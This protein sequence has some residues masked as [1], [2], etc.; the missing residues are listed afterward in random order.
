[1]VIDRKI[2][3]GVVAGYMAFF[4]AIMPT[5]YREERKRWAKH[6]QDIIHQNEFEIIDPGLIVSREDGI[7]AGRIFKQEN[8]DV[9]LVIPTMAAPPGY[10]WEAVKEFKD[11]PLIVWDVHEMKKIPD[12]YT[13][14]D[15][16]RHSSNVGTI[17][18]TNVALRYGRNPHIL[19][20]TYDD[21]KV[22]QRISQL[23]RIG[24]LASKLR[25]GNIG[26]IGEPIDGYINVLAEEQDVKEK[27]GLSM[28]RITKEEFLDVF[29]SITEKQL[30]K[31]REW[32][33]QNSVIEEMADDELNKSIQLAL[34]L[35]SITERYDLLGGAYN[36]RADYGVKN[37]DIG[38]IGC[39]GISYMA[40][41]GKPYTCTGDIITS[42]AMIVSKNLGSNVLYCECDQIDY[43]EDYMLMANTG[44]S[45]F[46][47]SCEKPCIISTGGHS[48][49]PVKGASLFVQAKKGPGTLI[50]LSPKQNA[51][52]GWSLIIAPGE[53]L[54]TDHQQLRV[55]NAMFR[56]KNGPTPEAF[57][58]WCL[59]GATHH[60]ALSTG[61]LVEDL[62]LLGDFLGIET[63]II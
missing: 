18:F 41:V 27:I 39:L 55:G 40:T 36:C 28:K 26:I 3:V 57:Q 24:G 8:I 53:I 59:A 58:R 25:K 51:K 44:E 54:G 62:L 34:T 35:E 20:G 47:F 30:A 63:V 9:I 60:G 49:Q 22:H 61:D 21:P 46:C 15:L 32:L 33:S 52:G 29:Q 16:V 4:D 5:G 37:P 17:M 43:I 11:L 13:M 7:N 6:L 23:I 12:D 31:K 19:V 56:F 48:G 1:M 50:G 14:R 38:V 45:D 10:S 42:I 2:K